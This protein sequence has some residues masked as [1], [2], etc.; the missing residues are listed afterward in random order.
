MLQFSPLTEM[1]AA[2]PP[3]NDDRTTAMMSAVSSC[4]EVLQGQTASVQPA[5]LLIGDDKGVAFPHNAA[6]DYAV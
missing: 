1:L 3:W 2:L 6:F 5:T 4:L